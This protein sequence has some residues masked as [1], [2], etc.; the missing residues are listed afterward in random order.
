MT[1][2]LLVVHGFTAVSF[3]SKIAIAQMSASR[4]ICLGTDGD[5]HGRTT[6]ELFTTGLRQ[7]PTGLR[8]VNE[9][10]WSGGT[11]KRRSGLGSITLTTKRTSR[12]R[13]RMIWTPAGELWAWAEHGRSPCIRMEWDGSTWRAD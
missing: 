12:R 8:G 2:Q 1:V 5:S 9:R 6:A 3:R 10:N 7:N 13:L 11:R 4:L